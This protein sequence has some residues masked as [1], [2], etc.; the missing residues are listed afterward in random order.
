MGSSHQQARADGPRVG[1]G[2]CQ[3]EAPRAWKQK[4]RLSLVRGGQVR[5]KGAQTPQGLP[6]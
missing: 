3:Q 1:W 6:P 4:E 2:A 5:H